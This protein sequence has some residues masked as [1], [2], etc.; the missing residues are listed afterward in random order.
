MLES[1]EQFGI[2]GE[3]TDRASR[4][5]FAD[6]GDR[7]RKVYFATEIREEFESFRQLARG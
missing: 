3:C 6:I 1:L 5:N 2:H 7:K 4:A